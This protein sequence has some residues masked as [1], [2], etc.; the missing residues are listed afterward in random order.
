MDLAAGFDPVTR[1]DWMKQVAGVLRRGN[2]DA[3]PEEIATAFA[4]RL[5]HRTEDGIEVQP[6]Y[7]AADTP[8]RDR[9]STSA[10]GGPGPAAVPWEIRQR[11]SDSAQA[12][13]ELEGGS[14][15]LLVPPPIETGAGGLDKT[16]TGVLLDLAP[17]S[18][19]RSTDAAAARSLLDV[20]DER[21]VPAEDRTGSLG[22][23]PLAGD[24][25]IAE[26]AALVAD[27][28]ARAPRA[29]SLVISGAGWHERGATPAQEIAWATSGAVDVVRAL[30][31]TGLAVGV[32]FRSFEFRFAA[33]AD[34][35]GTIAKLR[36][37]RRVWAR[38]AE[39][40]GA[41]ES[42]RRQAQHALSAR[43]MLT[44]YDPW[45]NALRNTVA[46]FAAG[47][48]GANAVTVEAHD[49]LTGG[50]D[51]GRRLARNTQTVLQMESHLAQVADIA[52]GSWYVEQLT[53]Q[54]ARAAWEQVQRIDAAGGFGEF[55]ASG[56]VDQLLSEAR[57]VRRAEV[58]TRRRPLTGLTEFP[59]LD[60]VVDVAP[61]VPSTTDHRVGEEIESLRLRADAVARSGSRP[62][63]YLATLGPEA[64]HTTRLTFARNFFGVAGIV[65]AAGTVDDYLSS[66]SPVV[67]LCSSDD[68]YGEEGS[69]AV[70]ALRSAGARTVLIAGRATGVQGV[71]GE[72]GIGSN[73]FESLDGV[74]DELIDGRQE[75]P[76]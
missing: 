6:L 63:V 69:E 12:I 57:D 74:L 45:V 38:V 4:K 15:G 3:G 35:F 68:L 49:L 13:E 34:Q 75:V 71:D 51:L 70:A 56:Q 66:R 59:D 16:L 43:S 58:V 31:G 19:E 48:A 42:D 41:A 39:L 9:A 21:A 50:S 40:A 44:L 11:A 52:G 47:V 46:C 24:P 76:A 23:D 54:L 8:V 29:R 64:V 5:V 65:G 55:L 73:L 72:I 61:S 7:T 26:I 28:A 20:W 37:A 25:E 60:E 1:D 17:V 33:T 10:I 22:L 14:T 18:L 30:T 2:P 53:D 67:C 62:T 27:A 36:A 32:T